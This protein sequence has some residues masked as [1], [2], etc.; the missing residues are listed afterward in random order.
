MKR[1]LDERTTGEGERVLLLW[2]DQLDLVEVRVEA[3][4]GASVQTAAV[5]AVVALDAFRHPY[6]YLDGAPAL[7]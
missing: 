1:E 3:R 4:D 5:P 6:L 7:A 2:D